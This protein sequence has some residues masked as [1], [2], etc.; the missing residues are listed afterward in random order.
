MKPSLSVRMISGNKCAELVQQFAHFWATSVSEEIRFT[1]L[2]D[3]YWR[4]EL[5]AFPAAATETAVKQLCWKHTQSRM[6]VFTSNTLE[7]DNRLW[8]SKSLYYYTNLTKPRLYSSVL[9]LWPQFLPAD[10]Q[11]RCSDCQ[12]SERLCKHHMWSRLRVISCRRPGA[13]QGEG[14][15]LSHALDYCVFYISRRSR[16]RHNR[17]QTTDSHDSPCDPCQK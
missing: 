9:P 3:Y 4:M 2:P 15:H 10:M 14:F 12:P 6:C 1:L 17:L 11:M 7:V 13:L 8:A 5:M 16:T